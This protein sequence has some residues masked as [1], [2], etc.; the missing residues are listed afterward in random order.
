MYVYKNDFYKTEI[1][2]G[3]SVSFY[4]HRG[5]CVRGVV[6]YDE[7]VGGFIVVRA[8]AALKNKV[9]YWPLTDSFINQS[10]LKVLD[11]QNE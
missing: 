2:D 4:D 5:Y 11:N 6:K 1:Y 3:D 8:G 10:R 9:N 7:A